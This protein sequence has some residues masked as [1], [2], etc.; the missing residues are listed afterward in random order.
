MAVEVEDMDLAFPYGL[1]VEGFGYGNDLAEASGAAVLGFNR[2]TK[3]VNRTAAQ[4]RQR[5]EW[6]DGFRRDRP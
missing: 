1:T 4:I 6:H 3:R 5:S 2:G